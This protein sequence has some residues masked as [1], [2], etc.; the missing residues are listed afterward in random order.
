MENRT[1]FF[2]SVSAAALIVAGAL[3]MFAQ[4]DA[5]IASVQ[6][7]KNM[8]SRERE[9][10]RVTG[11]VTARTKTGFFLQ[12]PDDK[13]DGNPNTSEGIFIYTRDEPSG[14]ATVGN[15]VSASGT[16]TEFRPRAEPNSLPITEI[17][18]QKGRDVVQVLSKAELPKPVVLTVD[19]FKLN[20]IDQLEKYEGMRVTVA[21]LTVV[22]PTNGRVDNKNNTS[23]SD[24]VFYGVLKGL[25]KPFREPGYNLY[26]Y[27]FLSD[28]EKEEFRKANPKLKIFDANP[29]RLR[30]ESG[31]QLGSQAIDVPALTELKNVTGVMHYAY[32]AYAILTDT[33]TRPA[34]VSYFKHPN[35]PPPTD[36]QFSVAG[37]NVENLFDE[38]DD[39]DIK[40]DLVT[41]ESFAKRLKKIS[42]AVRN[43]MQSPDVIGVV[44]AEN[45]AVLKRLAEKIN[46][47]TEAAG[48]PNPK[49][50]AYL[51]DG[52]DGRGI[53]VGFL[54]KSS[55]IKVVDTK[56][57]G[58][59]EKFKNPNTGEDNFL[60]DRPPLMLRASIHDAK[61]GLPFE[62]TVV[63]NH[64]KSFLGYDDPKQQDNVRTKKRLQA[65]FLAKFVQERQKADPKEKII[66]IG[67][68]N[69]FQFN[70]GIVDLMGTIKG[71]TAVKGEVLNPSED[72][73]D[74]DMVNLV[75][76]KRADEQYSY[77]F[78]G[79]GQVLD[80]I[81]V[82]NSLAAFISGFGW[83]RVNADFPESYR[84]DD[85]RPERF[86]DHDPAVAYFSLDERVEVKAAP[87]PA[88]KP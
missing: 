48:K 33:T 55:R 4:K 12:S 31:A 28:K 47:D 74:P 21:E 83:A 77:R 73:V 81:V 69:A 29:E 85:N 80:H 19:D 41:A 66:L 56:Q 25:P 44:E 57:L 87:T 14:E 35:M 75:D 9:V 67:D 36:R 46:A 63:V 61:T 22:A 43:V 37:M 64:L 70:D 53:D 8:S 84:A 62:F 51:I 27:I 20:T 3:S 71:K 1:V 16:V 17:S 72:L 2:R 59:A 60:N 78:D 40:E 68:F 6:G 79:N 18:M 39:P 26:D 13:T 5:S 24:G 15:L 34:V 76:L 11:I 54:V 23:V 58:K 10:V 65:E 52:N 50:E 42:L 38:I 86:S 49:Y 45:L 32:Q 82:S 7:D 88:A 30:I